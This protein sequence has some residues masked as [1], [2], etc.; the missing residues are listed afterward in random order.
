[1][2]K[3]LYYLLILPLSLL[4]L[5]VLFLF[6]DLFF[7]ISYR[8][9]AYRKKVIIGNLKN[10]FPEKTEA[11]I[12]AIGKEFYKYFCDFIFESI[13]S[14][15]ISKESVLER[16]KFINPEVLND[17]YDKNKSVMMICGHYNNWEL[18]ASAISNFVKHDAVGVYRPLNNT[19]FDNKFK[20]SRARY[21]GE[22][23]SKYVVKDY[24]KENADKN[25]IIGFIS[26]QCPKK[27]NK[28]LFWTK[29]LNQETA[30]MFGA[31]KYAVDFNLAVGFLNITRVKRGYYELSVEIITENPRDEEYAF[32]TKKHT[33]LLEKQILAEPAYWLWTHRRWKF[34]RKNNEKLY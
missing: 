1:M 13:K 12:N 26:D 9:L 15:S 20:E 27:N 2:S 24:L 34:T 29:F 8:V 10:S 32:I 30:V 33:Q 6:S 5:K 31:E 28:Q 23:L 7:F 22:L 17:L 25:I 3:I 11:E 19:F 18:A 4:P 14:F 16:C 21:G